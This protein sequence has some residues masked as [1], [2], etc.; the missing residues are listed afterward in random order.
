MGL[1][2]I[3]ICKSMTSLEM[4]MKLRSAAAGGIRKFMKRNLS[5][6][7]RSGDSTAGVRM[8]AV[9]TENINEYFD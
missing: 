1:V 5:L 8:S 6:C 4:T 3:Y 2:E 9:K 7:L